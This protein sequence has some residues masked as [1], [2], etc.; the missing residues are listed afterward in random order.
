MRLFLRSSFSQSHASKKQRDGERAMAM[1][2]TTATRM[3][4]MTMIL[5]PVFIQLL[6]LLLLMLSTFRCCSC[7]VTCYLPVPCFLSSFF[8]PPF[9]SDC[10]FS[11]VLFHQGSVQAAGSGLGRLPFGERVSSTPF[12]FQQFVLIRNLKT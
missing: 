4:M 7:S 9:P 10:C 5:P 3:M 1:R 2:I 11:G 8:F 6:V 12:L